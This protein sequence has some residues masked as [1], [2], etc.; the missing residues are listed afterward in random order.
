MTA[1][2]FVDRPSG[3][4]R[5]RAARPWLALVAVLF[6]AVV[7]AALDRHLKTIPRAGFCPADTAVVVQ[8]SD[9]P[10]FLDALQRTRAGV[11]ITEEL[12]ALVHDAALAVRIETGIRPTP[13]RWRVWLGFPLLAGVREGEWGLCVA[14]GLLARGV[15]ALNR[16]VGRATDEHE[17]VA[18][19]DTPRLYAY[20]RFYY[21]WREGCLILSR[22]PAYVRDALDA[23]ATPFA[24]AAPDEMLIAWKTDPPGSLRLRAEDGLPVSGAVTAEITPRAAP[25]TLADAWPESPLFSLTASRF[26]DA[27]MPAALCRAVQPFIKGCLDTYGVTQFLRC[28]PPLIDAWGWNQLVPDGRQAVDECSVALLGL[29]LDDGILPAPE[30]AFAMRGPRAGRDPHPLT[31]LIRET[32]FPFE[33]NGVP[34]MVSPVVGERWT[35]CLAAWEDTWLA[36]TREAA[37]ARVAGRLAERPGIRADVAVRVDW[38]KCGTFLERFL[39]RA[40]QLELVRG[41][42]AREAEHIVLPYTRALGRLGALRLQGRMEGDRLHFE[43][44]LAETVEE[45]A[46]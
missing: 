29:E 39:R 13:L 25:L 5:F 18:G 16:L 27:A 45:T 23:P 46:P 4:T 44:R 36:A 31:P 26:E 38:T 17:A 2:P 20:G 12:P 7:L 35:L 24:G 30:L 21:A 33:W 8:A 1:H 28:V 9:F 6:G 40:A 41:M 19:V 3:R 22:D 14:P 42:D 34:G 32:L 10:S 11:A 37:M 43:G 15:H